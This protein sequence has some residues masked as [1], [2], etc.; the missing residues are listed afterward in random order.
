MLT[1]CR[2]WQFT[3]KDHMT[4]LLAITIGRASFELTRGHLFIR[5]A[6]REMFVNR[7]DGQP[8]GLTAKERSGA[9]LEFWGL[10][11]Y[12]CVCQASA[13][14]VMLSSDIELTS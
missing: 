5:F 11:F 3:H 4:P 9:G 7:P 8:F 6:G 10:G 13:G 14:P 12:G 1:A 2:C